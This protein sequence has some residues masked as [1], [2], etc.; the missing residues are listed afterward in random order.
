MKRIAMSG[1]LLLLALALVQP[2]AAGEK[3]VT[4]QDEDGKVIVI[5]ADHEL[6]IIGEEARGGFL[7]VALAELDEETSGVK[8]GEGALVQSVYSDTPADEVGIEAGDIIVKFDGEKVKSVQQL[9]ELVR[10]REPGERVKLQAR[11]DGERKSFRVTL[12]ERERSFTL[13]SDSF[14]SRGGESLFQRFHLD[15]PKHIRIESMPGIRGLPGQAQLGVEVRDLDEDLADYFPGAKRGALILGVNEDS[16]AEAA[17]LKTGDVI[18]SLGGKQVEDVG[19]L[20][21]AVAAAAGEDVT[22]LVYYRHGHRKQ[23]EVAIEEG[24]MKVFM[25]RFQD[26]MDETDVNLHRVFERLEDTDWESKLEKL[27]ERL[28]QMEKRLEQKFEDK[29]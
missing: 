24:G 19:A 14:G 15:S 12:G 23:V 5:D 3:S 4:W 9:V 29:G 28:E 8:K 11:R 7:G 20:R 17:G 25:R 13:K 16:A 18:V 10:E 27:E 6:K 22:E 1:L 2:A 26:G 21:E